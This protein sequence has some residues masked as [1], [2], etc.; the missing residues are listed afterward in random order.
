MF[1]VFKALLGILFDYLIRNCA[2]NHR[3]KYDSKLTITIDDV[4][5]KDNIAI[6]CKEK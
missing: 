5:A 1:T 4:H 2:A 6:D 3:S